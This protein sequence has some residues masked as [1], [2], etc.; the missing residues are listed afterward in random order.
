MS[1]RVLF[2]FLISALSAQAQDL[3]INEV[4]SKNYSDFLDDAGDDSDW[5]E[6]YNQTN[7]EVQLSDYFLSDD[8]GDLSKWSFPDLLVA[9]YS[10]V[11]VFAN[12]ESDAGLAT[13]FSISSAGETIYLSKDVVVDSLV[14]PML[15][16]NESF[17]YNADG[18]T[19]VYQTASPGASNLQG[20]EECR[21]SF[22]HEAGFYDSEFDLQLFSSIENVEVYY[23]LDGRNPTL[24]D[25]IYAAPLAMTS[26]DGEPNVYAAFPMH[27]VD[28]S[29][30]STEVKKCNVIS[31]QAFLN[32]EQRGRVYRRSI[33][34]DDAGIERYQLPVLSII[35]EP[36]GFFDPDSGMMVPGPNA[37]ENI[38]QANFWK[39]WDAP[40]YV[41]WFENGSLLYSTD[42]GIELHGSSSRTTTQKPLKIFGRKKYGTKTIK[43]PFFENT[44][45]DQWDD[46]VL[47]SI[48][49]R[50]NDS[51]F[52][53][54]L[55]YDIITAHEDWKVGGSAYRY[56]IL[57]LDGEYW[58]IYSMREKINADF[59]TDEYDVLD[60]DLDFLRNV[61]TQDQGVVHGNADGFQEFITTMLDLDMST[62]ESLAFVETHIDIDNLIDYFIVETY[63]SNSDWVTHNMMLYKDREDP[64]FRWTFRLWDLDFAFLG[65]YK[66]FMLKVMGYTGEYN[67]VVVEPLTDEIPILFFQKLF[68]SE[69]LK[70]RLFDRY[71]FHLENTFCPADMLEIVEEHAA[72][73]QPEVEEHV[74]R[75]ESV[76][77]SLAHWESEVQRLRNFVNKRPDA[78]IDQLN[79][80]FDVELEYVLCDSMVTNIAPVLHPETLLINKNGFVNHSEQNIAFRLF[81][82]SGKAIRASVI[83][84]QG[85]Y[86]LSALG[87]PNGIYM[88]RYQIDGRQFGEKVMVGY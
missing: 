74:L 83:E 40:A 30:P 66:H 33:F 23:T 82:L 44:E 16:A 26:R 61:K 77:P 22:S 25:S 43:F 15:Y 5:I 73:L 3:R 87:L 59:I 1:W 49:A 52:N 28:D 50:G 10:L 47:K 63:G 21:I 9:P 54:E 62:A 80:A 70:T 60:E 31:A 72:R 75:Y 81:D 86:E 51:G 11:L 42:L 8:G 79:L 71:L 78:I 4:M 37:A 45:N 27:P 7:E 68:E 20:V 85:R 88:L 41:E 38:L 2:L 19:V 14:V 53:D 17:G 64:L 55:A 39:D 69:E 65:A 29:V 35:S 84:P 36:D 13:N 48:V 56:F 18:E 76:L 67:G 34:V 58:G 6:V 24:E 12:G 57:F 46:L 32:G